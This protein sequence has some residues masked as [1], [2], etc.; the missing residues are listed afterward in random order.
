MSEFVVRFR[1]RDRC[2][3]TNRS[4]KL[5]LLLGKR[6]LDTMAEE[7]FNTSSSRPGET[8]QLWVNLPQGGGKVPLTI[9]H[10]AAIIRERRKCK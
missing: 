8:L 4:K 2:A 10:V 5:A 7:F 6:E 9:D 1:G 3:I